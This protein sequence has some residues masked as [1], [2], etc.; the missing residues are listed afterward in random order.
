MQIW[1]RRILHRAS[2]NSLAAQCPTETIL[3]P[4][5]G[6]R[7]EYLAMGQALE[8][9]RPDYAAALSGARPSLNM[10]FS[11]LESGKSLSIYELAFRRL[12]PQACGKGVRQG[13]PFVRMEGSSAA[14]LAIP[15]PELLSRTRV[16]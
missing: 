4:G 11:S 16:P 14:R 2:G 6:S 7:A 1:V 10:R 3:T 15:S 12:K 13:L 5:R 9:S 8:A